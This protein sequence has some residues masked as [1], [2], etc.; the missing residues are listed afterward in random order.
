VH[1]YIVTP[2]PISTAYFTYSSHQSVCM[3]VH[4]P[5]VAR[6]RLGEHVPVAK[7]IHNNITIVGRVVFC[8][9]RVLSNEI[10]WVCLYI[11]LS[12]LGNGSVNMFPHQRKIV[13]SVVLYVVCVVSKESRRLV[14]HRNSCNF[15]LN[16]VYMI[17]SAIMM[18]R[19]R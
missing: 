15:L 10:L 11:F 13:G 16:E 7:N 3:Y 6:Q 12:L 19:T 8:G 9:I 4:L 18:S 5:I 2:Q 1:I 17:T 14:L